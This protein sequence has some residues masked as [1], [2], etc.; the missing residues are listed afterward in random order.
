MTRD[1]AS[2]LRADRRRIAS[3]TVETVIESGCFSW[4]EHWKRTLLSL[5]L[6]PFSAT[7]P[8]GSFRAT[9][10]SYAY[11]YL[12]DAVEQAIRHRQPRAV[13]IED[14]HHLFGPAR[15]DI[16]TTA[17]HAV[18]EIA[19]RTMTPH[20]L[21]GAYDMLRHLPENFLLRVIELR[22]YRWHDV[23]DRRFFRSI[24]ADLATML[25]G[26]LEGDLA[27]G[28]EYLYERSAGC[29][30]TLHNWLVRAL[31]CSMSSG[32]GRLSWEHMEATAPA[33]AESATIAADAI[34][35]ERLTADL[36]T[37]L[38]PPLPLQMAA[39]S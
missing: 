37:R 28:A 7:L 1:M 38:H 29:I 34:A 10:F 9:M 33:V 17:A 24:V 12:V 30:G 3:A 39:A 15:E 25:P 19:K 20:I 13:F 27:D 26:H 35:G 31:H 22:R 21:I 5:D 4:S 14:A 2:E 36:R 11:L 6:Q 23:H 18:G 16:G 8:H 32:V